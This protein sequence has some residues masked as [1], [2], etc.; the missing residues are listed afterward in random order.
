MWDRL[1]TNPRL[2][3]MRGGR[4]AAIE[5]GAVAANAG[6][7]AWLGDRSELRGKP[8]PA[9]AEMVDCG[10]RWITP[11]LIDCHTHLVHAGQR[12][13]EFELPLL[14]R[15]A[16]RKERFDHA[17]DAVHDDQALDELDPHSRMPAREAGDLATGPV[18]PA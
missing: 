14:F 4:Y 16:P 5:R 17:P 13:R 7:I 11:G 18:R 9:A 15:S 8:D 3:T 10:G 2:A 1:W 12:A 6:R